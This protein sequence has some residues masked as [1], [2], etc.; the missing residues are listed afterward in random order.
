M[1]ESATPQMPGRGLGLRRLGGNASMT[2][3]ANI[4]AAGLGFLLSIL[5]TR[6]LG[7]DGL[8]MYALALL[9][10]N[11]MAI[12]LEFGI[13]YANVYHIGRKDVNAHEVM[14]A[15]LWLWGIIAVVGLVISAAIIVLKGAEWFPGIPTAFMIIAVLS[16]P[17]SLLQSYCLSILQG[18]QDFKRYNY[19]TIVVRLTV[20]VTSVFSI[21]VFHKGVGAVLVAYFIGQMLSLVLTLVALRPYLKNAP[22]AH[23]RVH[24]WIYGRRAASYGWKQHL[25][26]IVA[27]VNYRVD[28]FFVN[29]LM[30][31][32]SAGVYFISIQLGESMWMISKVVS[33]VLLPRLA[34]LHNEE[35]TRLQLTPLVT[36]LVFSLT[37]LPTTRGSARRSCGPGPSTSIPTPRPARIITGRWRASSTWCAA[38]R[39]CA[40]ASSSS[41]W[42]RPVPATS[43]MCR[44]SCRTRRSTPRAMRRWNASWCAATARRW[45]STLTSRRLSSRKPSSGSTRSTRAS[46]AG[47]S[48]IFQYESLRVTLPSRKV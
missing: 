31:P 7:T 12:L 13:T 39:A 10:P 24:W 9:L 1:S 48:T 6:G 32:A 47:Y 34:E 41:S 30:N 37:A 21:L 29:L 42:R 16:F 46:A 35:Q 44:R 3:L 18:Y 5:L 19:L 45:S 36:R 20:L 28:L 23:E 17:P 26:A 2:F 8:G 27:F 43:S 40:G 11:T 38:R 25:S 4:A 15:N 14:R 33:T 22:P